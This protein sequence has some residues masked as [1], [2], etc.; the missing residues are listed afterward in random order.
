MENPETYS[1]VLPRAFTCMKPVPNEVFTSVKSPELKCHADLQS[2]EWIYTPNITVQWV[3][4]VDFYPITGPLGADLP[5]WISMEISCNHNKI[6]SFIGEIRELC[7]WESF[8]DMYN[9]FDRDVPKHLLPD[10]NYIKNAREDYRI[11]SAKKAENNTAGSLL[12]AQV[13]SEFSQNK[14]IL[15]DTNGE[16]YYTAGDASVRICNFAIY[17]ESGGKKHRFDRGEFC[18]TFPEFCSQLQK[19]GFMLA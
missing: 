7:D 14:H 1:A 13:A 12:L 4:H 10:A 9:L 8:N 17:I 2:V 11:R 18:R 5:F 19:N 3:I 6:V 15:S 16:L